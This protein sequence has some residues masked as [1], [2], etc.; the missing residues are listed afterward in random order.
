MQAMIDQ[1]PFESQAELEQKKSNIGSSVGLDIGY[2]LYGQ[3]PT[4][5]SGNPF[6]IENHYLNKNNEKNSLDKNNE[7]SSQSSFGKGDLYLTENDE[8]LTQSSGRPK[9]FSTANDPNLLQ[10]DRPTEF[11]MTNLIN[12]QKLTQP[13]N[14]S[15][16]FSM[17]NY[18][19]RLSELSFIGNYY[20]RLSEN[21]PYYGLYDSSG[22]SPY[23]WFYES[24]EER[25]EQSKLELQT[26]LNLTALETI[27]E[28]INS[29]YEA[30]SRE[31]ISSSTV[32][33][34]LE[35][36]LYMGIELLRLTRERIEQTAS[37]SN[38]RLSEVL[39]ALRQ[40]NPQLWSKIDEDI[41]K[42]YEIMQENYS[43]LQELDSSKAAKME[44]DL[45]LMR[46][47]AKSVVEDENSLYKDIAEQILQGVPEIQPY[48]QDKPSAVLFGYLLDMSEEGLQK[49]LDRLVEE[50]PNLESFIQRK[51]DGKHDLEKTLIALSSPQAMELLDD[52]KEAQILR[53]LRNM[54]DSIE[55]LSQI[56]GNTEEIERWR[57]N[58]EEFVSKYKKGEFDK[59]LADELLKDSF[60]IIL[61]N[62]EKIK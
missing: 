1:T 29:R 28:Y 53:S 21:D 32:E 2:E 24:L 10:P 57:K 12:N 41:A 8:N 7:R 45:F 62:K 40:L 26:E 20:D 25:V 55:A 9:E 54:N 49:T 36:K 59:D 22:F 23:G 27:N 52:T 34:N 47:W 17:E 4:Q 16:K 46:E 44:D 5:S 35:A 11:S 48:P 19:D 42:S 56:L 3:N 50:N 60:K 51:E 37:Q 61:N 18:Y 15:D 39:I 14:K 6:K 31:Y 58:Y 38:V 43:Q 33:E 13:L 30:F